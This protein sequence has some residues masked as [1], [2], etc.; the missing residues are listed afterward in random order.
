MKENK[1]TQG[2]YMA[3]MPIF[4]LLLLDRVVR[5]EIWKKQEI[6]QD[7]KVFHY[8]IRLFFDNGKCKVYA[9]DAPIEAVN[10]IDR[11]IYDNTKCKVYAFNASIKNEGK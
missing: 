9:F 8:K 10:F 2:A 1:D 11:I 4:P 7:E 3:D 6:R 5:V